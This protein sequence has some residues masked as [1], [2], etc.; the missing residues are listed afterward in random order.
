MQYLDN[1]FLFSETFIR[2]NSQEN[3]KSNN[4]MLKNTFIQ[5]CQWNEEYTKGEY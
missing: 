5:I 3:N 4:D 2:E 1:H